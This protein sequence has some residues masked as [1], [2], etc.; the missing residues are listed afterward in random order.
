MKM[1][2]TQTKK[3]MKKILRMRSNILYKALANTSIFF[4]LVIFTG[5]TPTHAQEVVDRIIAVVGENII[6]MQDL[7][8]RLRFVTRN[9]NNP[10]SS[11]QKAGLVQSQ[12]NELI[13]EELLFQY[14]KQQGHS[15]SQQQIDQAISQIEKQNKQPS[16]SFLKFAGKEQDTALKTIET[17]VIKQLIRQRELVPQ[18]NVGAQEVAQIVQSIIARKDQAS[19]KE[20][21]QIFVPVT[22]A[23]EE[24]KVKQ[25]IH[26]LYTELR[27][28]ASFKTLAQAYSRDSSAQTGGNIGWFRSQ[29]LVPEIEAIIEKLNKDDISRPIRSTNGWHIFKVLDVRTPKIPNFTDVNEYKILQLYAPIDST[30]GVPAALQNKKHAETFQTFK[31]ALTLHETELKK[32]FRELIKTQKAAS[33][34]YLAS[35]DMGWSRLNQHPKHIQKLLQS[36]QKE[37][38][39]GP[40]HSNEGTHLFF[41]ENI[42]KT[43]SPALEAL[44]SRV[45][46]TLVARQTDLGLR[47]LLRDLKRRI[48]TDIRL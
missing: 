16:G 34:L 22:Q 36:A 45:Q 14:A 38:I 27:A 23:K 18:A 39:L 26:R 46:N 21:A 33:P 44:K 13:E 6:T 1:M 29:E 4:M 7:Q 17:S 40:V 9:I 11:S 12:L 31:D 24:Q 19:E 20:L 37:T 8:K 15:V 5:H 35:G 2:Q 25:N 43:P 28:G 32:H 3:P 48:Y 30:A 41:I 10:L 47:R 42:R